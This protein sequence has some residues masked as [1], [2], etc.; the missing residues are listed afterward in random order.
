MLV[1]VKFITRAMARAEPLT[2]FV[3]GDNMARAGYGGQAKE[4]RGEQNAIGIPTKNGP[5][6]FFSDADFAQAKVA[7]DDA[8]MQLYR[9]LAR[10][11]KIVWP[12]DGIGT[13]LA[14]LQTKAPT[15]WVYLETSRIALEMIAHRCSK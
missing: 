2:L 14:Q 6:V 12:A 4:L 5:H 3:F 7:I 15:I 9:Q 8:F 10:G 13:G 1:K 11:G